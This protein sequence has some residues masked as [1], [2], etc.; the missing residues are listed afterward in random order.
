MEYHKVWNIIRDEKHGVSWCFCFWA[1]RNTANQSHLRTLVGQLHLRVPFEGQWL[2]IISSPIQS[3][4]PESNRSIAKTEELYSNA[5]RTAARD[6][7][8]ELTDSLI[9]DLLD[10][11]HKDWPSCSWFAAKNRKGTASV[12]HTLA[13]GQPFHDYRGAMHP[14]ISEGVKRVS[15]AVESQSKGA[16]GL[17]HYIDQCWDSQGLQPVAW[18]PS[19]IFNDGLWIGDDKSKREKIRNM[20]VTTLKKL[21]L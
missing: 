10:D 2:G 4:E 13:T 5:F 18:G 6:I 11:M 17:K 8:G 20:Q 19:S 15:R 12:G 21:P 1:K 7:V 3:L 9:G 14:E 16:S